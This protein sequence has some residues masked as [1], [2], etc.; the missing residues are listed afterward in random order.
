MNPRNSIR[1][2][3]ICCIAA[4]AAVGC[5][6]PAHNMQMPDGPPPRHAE[7]DK[8][9]FMVGSWTATGDMTMYMPDGKTQQQTTTGTET[10]S[11]ACDNRFLRSEF[12]YGM[13]EMGTMTGIS[14][15]NWCPEEKEYH[16]WY[17]DSF[18]MVGEGEMEYDQTRGLWVMENEGKNPMTGRPQRGEGTMKGS[19]DGMSMEWTY[20]EWDKGSGKKVMDI[21]GTSRKIGGGTAMPT[22]G[23]SGT[24]TPAR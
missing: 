5:E 21:K 7:L 14:M 18:G 9:N 13:G 4:I 1:L 8:L 24:M 23:T 11:W 22:A 6:Q 2:F 10:V 19:A 20:T 3:S 12:S 17:F 16:S 15:M